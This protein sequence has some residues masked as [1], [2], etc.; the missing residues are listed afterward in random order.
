MF[1]YNLLLLLGLLL[2]IMI[3]LS[4]V[5]QGLGRF[6]GAAFDIQTASFLAAKSTVPIFL[7]P[8]FFVTFDSIPSPLRWLTY[9]SFA[10]YGFEGSMLSIYAYDRA[11]L[12]RSD[13]YCH[14]RFP[15][16]FLEQFDLTQ[17]SYSWSIV[18]LV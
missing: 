2:V 7:V 16:K 5:G 14:F 9:F 3:W 13:S 11:P 10:R 4:L 6:F 15:Q 12:A 1:I 8:G 17:S 18:G